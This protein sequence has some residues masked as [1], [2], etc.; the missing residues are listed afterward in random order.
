MSEQGKY[1]RVVYGVAKFHI[2][3]GMYSIQDVENMLAEF[4]EAKTRHDNALAVSMK[5][6]PHE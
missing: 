1:E 5:E 2:E 3:E 6:F 4:K